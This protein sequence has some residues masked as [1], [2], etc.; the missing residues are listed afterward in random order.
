M[1]HSFIK[2]SNMFKNDLYFIKEHKDGFYK[3]IGRLLNKA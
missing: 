3:E 2:F 1:K